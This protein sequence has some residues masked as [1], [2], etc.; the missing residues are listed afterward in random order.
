M[1]RP[2]LL[3]L[4]HAAVAGVLLVGCGTTLAEPLHQPQPDPRQLMAIH[5]S[6]MSHENVTAYCI[7]PDGK[8]SSIITVTSTGEP[9]LDSVYR[10]TI[11]AWRFKP[12][13]VRGKPD[14]EC[15]EARFRVRAP[16]ASEPIELARKEGSQVQ[17]TRLPSAERPDGSGPPERLD[18]V[19]MHTGLD[20]AMKLART[21]CAS[22]A[23]LGGDTLVLE[24]SVVSATGKI[25]EFAATNAAADPALV[26]C[27]GEVF[28]VHAS[29][30]PVTAEKDT[31]MRVRVAF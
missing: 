26:R 31:R 13:Q 22:L 18:R 7:E 4:W 24:I 9:R 2:M 23:R 1:V 12:A 21:E 20:P 28:R 29:F 3:P 5:S 10:D 27:V 25:R 30:R 11:A 16:A 17:M 19:D 8:T 15:R 6:G 14:S